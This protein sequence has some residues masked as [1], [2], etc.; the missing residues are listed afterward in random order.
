VSVLY[1]DWRRAAAAPRTTAILVTPPVIVPLTLEQGKQRAGLDWAPGDARDAM[2]TGWL[3]T[4][5]HQVEEDTGIALFTQTWDVLLD[6][7]PSSFELP[8]RPVQSVIVTSYDSAGVVHTLDPS[9]YLIGPSSVAP[10]P[11]RLA[12][13]PTGSWPTDLRT[14]QP[15]AVRF[16]AGFTTLELLQ[17]TAPGLIDAVGI[18]VAHAATA[19]RDRFQ[20]FGSQLALRDEYEEKIAPYRLVVVG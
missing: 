12:L 11:T 2:M 3:A 14:F 17:A 5:R 6:A 4:A 16:V 8:R 18:L 9:N 10:V 20:G 19:G 1:P 7:W 13:S 15:W